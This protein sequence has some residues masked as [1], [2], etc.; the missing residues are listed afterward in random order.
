MI[1]IRSK[2]VYLIISLF[3]VVW[4]AVGQ[5]LASTF[6]VALCMLAFMGVI[7]WA[8]I[9]EF[10]LPLL[11]FFLPWSPLLKVG[12]IVTSIYTI[13][14]FSV[15]VILLFGIKNINGF[16][17]IPAILLLAITLLVK[18]LRGYE[19][20]N[21][22][23][24]FF[25]F[26]MLF[27]LVSKEIGVK[28][29]YYVLTLFFSLGI[30]TAA[31][32][33]QALAGF[34]NIAKYINVLSYGN[35]TRLSGYY[36]DPN[37]YSAHITA[38]LAGALL[39]LSNESSRKRKILLLIIGVALLYCGFLSISKTFA[40]IAICVALLWI[41]NL[42]FQ[43]NKL[44]MKLMMIFALVF[45]LLFILSSTVFSDLVDQMIG[46]FINESGT[47]SAFTTHRSELWENYLNAFIEDPVL[48][49]F[50]MGFSKGALIMKSS[51]NT[52]IQSVFQFGLLGAIVFFVWIICYVR[53]TLRGAKLRFGNISQFLMILIGAIGPWMALDLLFFDELFLIIL[54][55]CIGVRYISSSH[56]NQ[57]LEAK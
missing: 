8:S 10:A 44:S 21:S 27:P 22:Y 34:P 55:M 17:L 14:L 41:L 49:F 6:A 31:L 23:I 37:F 4:L 50:G 53:M 45:S 56:E 5:L 28:Y 24:T 38:A 43:K 29:D 16:F 57:T 1:T 54:Y 42:L 52:I 7:I 19:I 13:A 40:L 20:D 36:R 32:S 47:L 25:A 46:R 3:I 11:L 48:L 39:L 51:H 2:Y 26:L 9:K 30:I 18:T 33:A 35:M 12:S 15:M